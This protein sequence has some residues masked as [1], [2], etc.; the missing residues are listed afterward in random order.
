[1]NKKLAIGG[2]TT[3]VLFFAIG[4]ALFFLGDRTYSS[5][6]V[7]AELQKE[8]DV[9][10]QRMDEMDDEERRA[11]REAF[12]DNI[13]GLSDDQRREFFESSRPM[14]MQMAQ[15]R[16]DEFFSL[17]PEEQAQRLDE[18]IDRQEAGQREGRGERSNRGDR[19][20]RTAGERS[21]RMKRMLDRTTPEMRARFSEF[22]RLINERREE[23]GLPPSK[24]PPRGMFR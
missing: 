22:R 23:R 4:C 24:G 5:D 7:V 19:R 11:T 8:R 14:F 3:L 12:R 10:L 20:P 18:I 13:Q 21:E 15:R 9:N 6:P 16:M 17:T 1:M 2:A